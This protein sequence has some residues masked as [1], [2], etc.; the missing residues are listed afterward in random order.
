MQ[1]KQIPV[2]LSTAGS[3]AYRASAL[4][5][6][7]EDLQRN[8][9]PNYQP[10]Y[11]GTV[12]RLYSSQ[13]RKEG[14][15]ESS[16]TASSVIPVYVPVGSES[17]QR[18]SSSL[19]ESELQESRTFRPIQPGQYVN[20]A[21]K[22]HSSTVL[23]V[24]VRVQYVPSSEQ[25]QQQSRSEFQSGS[26]SNVLRGQPGHRVT[27]YPASTYTSSAD[28]SSSRS[29][30]EIDQ[31]GGLPEK[32]TSYGSYRAPETLSQTRFSSEGTQSQLDQT[33]VAPAAVT[34]PIEGG[35]SRVASSGASSSQRGYT[36]SRV[37]PVYPVSTIESSS[38]SSRTE[39]EREQ[40][41]LTQA[42]PTYIYSGRN[43]GSEHEDSRGQLSST[44]I[45]PTYVLSG[46]TSTGSDRESS[47][48]YG[49]S[50][51]TTYFVAPSASNTRTQTQY[52][53]GTGSQ[54]QYQSGSGAQSQY[55]RQGYTGSNQQFSPY[56]PAGR[57]STFTANTQAT[58]SSSADRLSTRFGTGVMQSGTDDLNTYMTEAERLARLQ[59]QQIASSSGSSNV[60]VTNSEA[61][62]RTLQ[63]AANLDSAAAQFVSSS[64]VANRNSE[65]DTLSVDSGAAVGPGGY[66]RVK[67]WQKQS[68]WASG[69]QYGT[70][71]QPKSYSM[72]STAE[73]EK[74]NIDG[75]ETGFKAATSTLENDGKV[76]TYSIHTP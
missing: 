55:Q 75:Q 9:G 31:S 63:N 26:E 23:N 50:G 70:D 64:N 48:Q 22:P 45:R 61:N 28:K 46:R 52:Q 56:V 33:R 6:N 8:V 19:S 2:D 58:G 30:Q 39:E 47:S 27:Y 67:S 38:A 14:A 29:E 21:A 17:S 51:A 44:N 36:H 41:R 5:Q 42:R 73:S 37:V 40:R 74:H 16:R 53:S 4:S 72:L 32:F 10:A 65:L 69:A 11:G 62:R 25:M 76:S 49:S 35:S 54:S 68:K 13:R 20:I 59:Q 12:S 1:Q 3:S 60:A 15:S 7:E 18:S 57:A 34:Y 66:K 24:P 43:V 71:G